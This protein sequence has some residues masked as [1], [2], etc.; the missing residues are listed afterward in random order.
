MKQDDDDWIEELRRTND[1]RGLLDGWLPRHSEFLSPKTQEF[2]SQMWR[3]RGRPTPAQ[4]GLLIKHRAGT[5]ALMA[6][7]Q[8]HMEDAA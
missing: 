2:A 1:W 4:L 3:W 7:H 5:E 6:W 8:L